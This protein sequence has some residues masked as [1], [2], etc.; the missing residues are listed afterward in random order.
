M[1]TDIDGY[2]DLTEDQD[3]EEEETQDSIED[4]LVFEGI[5]MDMSL[6]PCL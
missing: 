4:D 3:T 2:L 1:E 5:E 6:A